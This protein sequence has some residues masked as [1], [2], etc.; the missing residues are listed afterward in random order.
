MDEL[1]IVE[2]DFDGEV[3]RTTL[4]PSE[5]SAATVLAVDDGSTGAYAVASLTPD[6][7]RAL[8]VWGQARLVEI[9]QRS[10]R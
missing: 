5:F 7:L 10:A 9:E 2:R 4:R 6:D 3:T 8:V 1:E